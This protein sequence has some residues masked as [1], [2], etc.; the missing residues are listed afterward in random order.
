MSLCRCT[1]QPTTSNAGCSALLCVSAADDLLAV[2]VVADGGAVAAAAADAA[3]A[4]S[5]QGGGPSFLGVAL[6]WSFQ[7]ARGGSGGCATFYVACI[8][9]SLSDETR[10]R[11]PRKHGA[12]VDDSSLQV[13]EH[14]GMRAPLALVFQWHVPSR[15]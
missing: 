4:S 2:V 3:A 14:R 10:G 11:K 13:G 5:R 6:V 9:S 15:T 12:L 1:A 7:G 8:T